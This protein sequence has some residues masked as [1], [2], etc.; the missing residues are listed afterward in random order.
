MLILEYIYEVN[1]GN[2]VSKNGNVVSLDFC[3]ICVYIK[4]SN[5]LYLWS[6]FWLFSVA[7]SY[8]V[9]K[10]QRREEDINQNLV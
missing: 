10:L 5:L 8:F 6:I 9:R 3:F 1:G 4:S 7:L 2:K